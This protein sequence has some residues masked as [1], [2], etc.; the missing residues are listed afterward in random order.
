MDFL[1][2]KQMSLRKVSSEYTLGVP[3]LLNLTEMLRAA[4]AEVIPDAKTTNTGGW[5]WRGFYLP[6]EYWVGIRYSDPLVVTFEDNR[7]YE[8]VTYRRSLDLMTEDFF[9]LDKDEQFERVAEFLQTAS[10]GL[11]EPLS[12]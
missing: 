2:E 1:D 4:I 11:H 10:G 8:P 5:N 12:G 9:A 3:A 6:G 7:G